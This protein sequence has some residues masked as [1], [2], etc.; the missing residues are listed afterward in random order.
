M[1]SAGR[2]VAA[3]VIASRLR[4][5]SRAQRSRRE[6]DL[7]G[8]VAGT[9]ARGAAASAGG[10]RPSA[11]SI[12]VPPTRKGRRPRRV[13]GS[14]VVGSGVVGSD[15]VRLRS[16]GGRTGTPRRWWGG[17]GLLDAG[18]GDALDEPALEGEEDQQDR[19]DH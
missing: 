10:V 2:P 19:H 12:A 3:G 5:V 1:L 16:W 7:G 18:G 17:F 13:V 11:A 9:A 14:G 4:Q 15:M 6:F 8:K